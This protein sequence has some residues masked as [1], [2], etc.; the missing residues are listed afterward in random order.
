MGICI[1]REQR[2]FLNNVENVRRMVEILAREEPEKK[3]IDHAVKFCENE[4]KYCYV[5]L[6]EIK[7]NE[8][9]VE[10]KFCKNITHPPCTVK[11]ETC[12][13]CQRSF[14]ER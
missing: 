12:G 4:D 9:V 7:L 1:S 14:F 8:A 13:I 11:L 2:E 10:C 5:C 3:T 6:E